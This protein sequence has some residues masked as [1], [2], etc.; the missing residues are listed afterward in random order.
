MESSHGHTGQRMAGEGMD[1]PEPEHGVSAP[2]P[3]H[4][5]PYYIIFIT[6][7]VLT[8]VTVLAGLYRFPQEIMNLLIALLIAFVKASLVAL[9]FMHLKFEG[10]LIYLILFVPLGLCVLLVVAL[11]P[12]IVYGAPWD[13]MV[14]YPGADQK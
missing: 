13:T 7:V 10:K 3:D 1:A 2:H 14:P 4:K 6:L 11:I 12:D 8:V 5:V 9:F